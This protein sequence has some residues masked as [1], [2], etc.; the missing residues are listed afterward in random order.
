MTRRQIEEKLTQ[1]R[2]IESLENKQKYRHH[3]V[4]AQSRRRIRKWLKP[5]YIK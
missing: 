4:R 1:Y 2:I 3:R 5:L